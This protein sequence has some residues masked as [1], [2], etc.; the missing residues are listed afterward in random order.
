MYYI[1]DKQSLM[2]QPKINLF[3]RTDLYSIM[4][5]E[6]HRQESATKYNNS[7][8]KLDNQ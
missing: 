4:L 3:L 8:H 6:E 2:S 5:L 7:T 1:T